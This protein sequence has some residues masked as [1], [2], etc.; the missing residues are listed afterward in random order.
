VLRRIDEAQIALQVGQEAREDLAAGV[1]DID[2]AALGDLEARA[3]C[4]DLGA[5]RRGVV[6]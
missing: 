3:Q 4:R 1:I 5:V 2:L 6:R